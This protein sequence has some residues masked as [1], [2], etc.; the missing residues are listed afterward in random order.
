[1]K[2]AAARSGRA[3]ES[4]KLIAVTKTVSTDKIRQAVEEGIVDIGE[5]RLQ[6]ALPKREE[7]RDLRLTWHFIG[8]LQTN[9]AK[10]VA[11]HFDWI[12]CVD[13]RELA[14]KLNQAASKTL[15]VLVEVNTGGEA[16]KS[17]MDPRDLPA[18]IEKFSDYDRLSLRGLMAIPPFFDNPEDNRPFSFCGRDWILVSSD[19]K[20]ESICEGSSSR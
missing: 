6:E 10:K 13:R 15:P 19:W 1:M 5:N 17:G 16:S 12:Q 7:L 14:E 4:I 8:H 2:Q 20:K 9:K 18:F 11:E 3:S